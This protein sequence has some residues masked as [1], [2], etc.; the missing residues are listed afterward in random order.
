[1]RLLIELPL[2]IAL[3]TLAVKYGWP[4]TI[5]FV[6]GYILA[7]NFKLPYLSNRVQV[8]TRF[9]ICLAFFLA[10]AITA[11]TLIGRYFFSA[12]GRA[13]IEAGGIRSFL[14]VTPGLKVLWA[15]VIGF[16]LIALIAAV[17]LVPYGQVAGQQMYSQYEQYKGHEGEAARTA[18][19]ILLGISGGTWVISGGQAEVKGDPNGALARFGGPGFVIVQEGHAAILEISGKVSE[20]IG[21][22]IAWLKPFERISMVVPLQTRQEKVTVEQVATRD[23]VIIEEFDVLVFHKWDSGPE[24]GRIQD[25]MFAYNKQKLLKDVWKPDG[26]DWRGG[27]RSV[28]ETATRDV[29]GRFGLEDIFPIS[30]SFRADFRKTLT[31]QMNQVTL[32]LMGVV[33]STVDINR[34]KI[35]EEAQNRLLRRWL[36]DRDVQIAESEKL[37]SLVQGEAE[38]T[39]FRLKEATRAES[40][41]RMM[42]A[43]TEGIRQVRIDG[44]D[45][46][47]LIA[48][49][50]IQALQKMAE[51]P[52]TKMFFPSDMRLA[53]L[54]GLTGAPAGALDHVGGPNGRAPGAPDNPTGRE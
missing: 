19:N 21:S 32:P 24:D 47:E 6:L 35:P 36:A 49:S 39:R 54:Q 23:H 42:E 33:I 40:Q 45:A 41:T 10:F 30:D 53:D 9:L 44:G 26:S 2:T 11:S 34:V 8:S 3:F 28:A 1:M 12:G 18:I 16:G 29:V 15:T 4:Y 20:V 17:I 25:G 7:F 14:L 48:L 50:F 27:V 51:D 31:E 43:I 38:T 46:R 13:W 52:A 5:I 37:T 22:G